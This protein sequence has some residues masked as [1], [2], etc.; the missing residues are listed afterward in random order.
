[1]D[2]STVVDE[3]ELARKSERIQ[4]VVGGIVVFAAVACLV[5]IPFLPSSPKRSAYDLCSEVGISHE[6]VDDAIDL[7]IKSDAPHDRKLQALLDSFMTPANEARARRCAHAILR[8]AIAA[9]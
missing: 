5:S 3:L 6:R 7:M 9:K 1:L 4:K 8:D 2:P